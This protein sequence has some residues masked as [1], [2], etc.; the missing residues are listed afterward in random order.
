MWSTSSRSRER[1][2]TA[3]AKKQ[4]RETIACLEGEHVGSGRE[5]ASEVGRST[6][7]AE[8]R[9]RAFPRVPDVT[10]SEVRRAVIRKFRY[11]LIF[12]VREADDDCDRAF[13]LVTSPK[14]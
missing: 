12:E 8:T 5:L 3:R 9:V 7:L 1:P 2:W 13:T 4:L 11:W 6:K 14:A 10:T